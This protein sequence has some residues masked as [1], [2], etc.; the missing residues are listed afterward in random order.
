MKRER[1]FSTRSLLL[2]FF[3]RVIPLVEVLC[4]PATGAQATTRSLALRPGGAPHISV[5]TCSCRSPSPSYDV[6]GYLKISLTGLLPESPGI[7]FRRCLFHRSSFCYLP[8]PPRAPPRLSWLL[9]CQT[10]GCGVRPSSPSRPL[11]ASRPFVSY[12]LGSIRLSSLAS[13]KPYLTG[14]SPSR[15]QPRVSLVGQQTGHLCISK[16]R[17]FAFVCKR[18]PGLASCPASSTEG[19]SLFSAITPVEASGSAAARSWGGPSL[20][21]RKKTRFLLQGPRRFPFSKSD[22]TFFAGGATAV[23]SPEGCFPQSLST[24]LFPRLDRL[25]SQA[26]SYAFSTRAARRWPSS[27]YNR[28]WREPASP[29]CS[30]SSSQQGNLFRQPTT[31]TT[32]GKEEDGH[33]AGQHQ[34]SEGHHFQMTGLA[35]ELQKSFLCYAYSTILSRALPDARD[36]LKPVHR[37]LIYAMHVRRRMVTRGAGLTRPA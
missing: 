22:I 14:Q 12:F 2:I 26:H 19:R 17:G 23:A 5:F 7:S 24:E 30:A 35:D 34:R 9:Q 15:R 6:H 1:S 29:L 37:R 10:G 31:D 16:D 36:G 33:P 18:V 11:F 27:S 3:I 4:L 8:S 32:G 28:S 13:A 20:A 25:F 21:R